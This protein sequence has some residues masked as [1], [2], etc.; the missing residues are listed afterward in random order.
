MTP[1]ARATRD[2][3]LGF[4]EAAETLLFKAAQSSSSLRGWHDQWL[5]IG[6]TADKVQALRRQL[7]HA[8]APTSHDQEPRTEADQ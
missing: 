8:P 4:I 6:D 5:A 7:Q 2:A 3:T 1:R